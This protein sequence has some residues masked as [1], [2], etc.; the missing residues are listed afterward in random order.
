MGTLT[1]QESD[2]LEEV[3]LAIHTKEKRFDK[4]RELSSFIITTNISIA[5]AKLLKRAKLGLKKQ[6]IVPFLSLFDKKK[7][8]LSK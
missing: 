1:K 4:M 8:F 5:L 2:A 3:F 6:K 7:K